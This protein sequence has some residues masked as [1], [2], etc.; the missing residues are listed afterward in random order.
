[1]TA[2]NLLT[3]RTLLHPL[4]R[5]LPRGRS[6][7]PD[8]GDFIDVRRRPYAESEP[9][10]FDGNCWMTLFGINGIRMSRTQWSMSQH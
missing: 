10:S 3:A 7:I 4:K 6:V 9:L 1:M 8:E 5:V 2:V